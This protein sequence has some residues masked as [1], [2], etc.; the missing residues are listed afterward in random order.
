M[1]TTYVFPDDWPVVFPE[2]TATVSNNFASAAIPAAHFYGMAPA[3]YTYSVFA[4]ATDSFGNES[5]GAD[6]TV[7]FTLDYMP[8]VTAIPNISWGSLL[9]AAERAAGGTISV[10]TSNAI[11]GSIVR[12]YLSLGPGI[13]ADVSRWNTQT[14]SGAATT[15]VSFSPSDLSTLAVN[16]SYDVIATVETSAGTRQ[17]IITNA[18]DN[19]P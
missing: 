18:F 13:P 5:S 17:L 8:S 10:T 11:P 2:Y 1:S 15:I 12:V 7:G 19:Q 9:T 6:F 16:A 14:V 3:G 4:K